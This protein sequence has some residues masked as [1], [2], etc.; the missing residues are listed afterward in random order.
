[1]V[2]PYFDFQQNEA[3]I[4]LRIR[5]SQKDLRRAELL[6][7]IRTELQQLFDLDDRDVTIAGTMVLYNNVLQS[8]YRSQS[9]SFGAVLLGVAVMFLVLFRSVSLSI[10]GILPN[11][12]AAAIVLGL[13]GWV[14]IPLD[15]MTITIAAIAIGIAVDNAIHYIYRYRE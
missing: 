11:V 10:I 13:M 5:D 2:D 1:M 15:I 12:L 9:A 7:R 8:L 3:R 6:E 4:Q 14:G